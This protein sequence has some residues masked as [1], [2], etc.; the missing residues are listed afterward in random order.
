VLSPENLEQR[1]KEVFKRN[2][3]DCRCHATH[4]PSEEFTGPR[5]VPHLATKTPTDRAASDYHD[6][7][8][9]ANIRT[10]AWMLGL[11]VGHWSA[12]N[13]TIKTEVRRQ[14]DYEKYYI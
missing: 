5:T 12:P 13:S 4:A 10:L 6:G 14:I 3:K 11:L 9:Q 8:T 1:T 2:K 7:Q